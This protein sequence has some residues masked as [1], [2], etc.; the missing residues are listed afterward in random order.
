M[1]DVFPVDFVT[2]QDQVIQKGHLERVDDLT[3]VKNWLN[4]AYFRVCIETDF[5]ESSFVMGSPLSPG[6]TSAVIPSGVVKLEYIVPTGQDGT[7]WGPVTEVTFE[8]L[9][10][11]RAWQGGQV[12]TG[13]PSQY[14]FR[15]SGSPTI[16][17]WPSALGGEVFT[18]YGA[19]MPTALVNDTD[20]P[21]FPEPYTKAIEYAALIEA[22]EQKSDLL[23]LQQFSSQYEDWLERF[24]GFKNLRKS[25]QTAQFKVVRKRPWPKAN[26]VDQGY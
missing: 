6:Q 20:V 14:S 21:I 26:S 16:E 22:A 12:S 9:L 3:R 8:E 15:S 7:V 11:V 2:M 17:F 25:A 18:F 4:N 23:M 13:A 10:Q 19:T 5:Y 24:R 1:P